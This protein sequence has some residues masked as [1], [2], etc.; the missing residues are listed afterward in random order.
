MNNDD[1]SVPRCPL[2]GREA[3]WNTWKEHWFCSNHLVSVR[4]DDRIVGGRGCVGGGSGGKG[5]GAKLK[6][7]KSVE[8][9]KI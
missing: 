7:V 4:V 9:I 8:E 2:C 6:D 3:E 1:I 5:V